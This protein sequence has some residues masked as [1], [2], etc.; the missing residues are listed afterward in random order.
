MKKI[1]QYVPSYSYGGIESFTYEINKRLKGRYE[2]CYLVE[3]DVDEKTAKKIEA[4][5]GE[6]IRIP[7]MTK[8]SFW[9]Y[10][11]AVRKLFR[12]QKFDVVHVHDCNNRF[13]V[14]LVAKLHGVKCRV[15]HVH[16]KDIGGSL[17]AR[18]IKKIGIKLNVWFSTVCLACSD[19]A[20]KA[21][22]IHKYK[23]MKNCISAEDFRYDKRRGDEI[24]KQYKI[25]QDDTLLL[26]VGRVEK[27]KNV[28]FLL[29]VLKK[30]P[31][32][33]RKSFALLIIGD[34]TEMPQIK[35]VAKSIN[36]SRIIIAGRQEGLADY[37][38]ASDYLCLPSL[39]E[40]FPIT[41]LEAQANGLNCLASENVPNVVNLNKRV[42]FL[43]IGEEG[44]GDWVDALLNTA[45]SS[46]QERLG[47]VELIK[48]LKYDSD[49]TAKEVGKIYEGTK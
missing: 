18:T 12:S 46:Q 21:K 24:R 45:K 4:L 48:D 17:I 43:R 11:G 35:K 2:F 16:S 15:Y 47:G 22:K 33:K 23:T 7:N 9:G 39:A 37:Y 8:E 40:G 20:A 5:G 1:L 19:E 38:S 42:R 41:L 29:E 25:L 32:E 27:V 31:A 30:M 36:G 14:T 13:L 6:I 10:V 28:G 26:F 3:K 44:I 49:S 34:G